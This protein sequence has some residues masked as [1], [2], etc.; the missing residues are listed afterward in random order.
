MS[1]VSGLLVARLL[2]VAQIFPINNY[3]FSFSVFCISLSIIEG[4]DLNRGIHNEDLSINQCQQN[5]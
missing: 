5:L 3:I 1:T 4:V 2:T